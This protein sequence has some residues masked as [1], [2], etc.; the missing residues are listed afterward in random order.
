MKTKYPSFESEKL[1][2][3]EYEFCL[4][5][6]Y[7]LRRRRHKLFEILILPVKTLSQFSVAIEFF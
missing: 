2:F 6:K 4:G 7:V 1:S 5:N 3:P